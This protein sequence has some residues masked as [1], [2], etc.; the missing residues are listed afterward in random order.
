MNHL[1]LFSFLLFA[2]ISSAQQPAPAV[3]AVSAR[4]ISPG[5]SVLG[6][7]GMFPVERTTFKCR[8]L[9]CSTAADF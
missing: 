7:L 8:G 9:D 2:T 1:I 3:P 4:R 6:N 5:F